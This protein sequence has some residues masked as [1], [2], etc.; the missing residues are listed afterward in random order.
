MKKEFKS[1]DCI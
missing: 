1:G